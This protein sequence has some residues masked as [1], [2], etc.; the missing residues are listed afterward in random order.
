MY[1]LPYNKGSKL[2]QFTYIPS[3]LWANSWEVF[4]V[5]EGRRRDTNNFHAIYDNE[6]VP[7]CWQVSLLW[8][9]IKIFLCLFTRSTGRTSAYHHF[10]HQISH[11][12]YR[13]QN[14]HIAALPSAVVIV[15]MKIL[16]LE[17]EKNRP[18]FE[19]HHCNVSWHIRWLRLMLINYSLWLI[20]RR[21]SVKD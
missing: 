2:C 6:E 1:Y 18:F 4:V 21:S 16:W 15:S 19:L 13:Q 8:A 20:A 7:K 12:I 3:K 9:Q 17:T 5:T 11:S 14:F 10:A